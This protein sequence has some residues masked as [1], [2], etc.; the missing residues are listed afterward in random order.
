MLRESPKTKEKPVVIMSA[1]DDV[2]E[3]AEAIGADGILPK[4]FT[5]AALLDTIHRTL[6]GAETNAQAGAKTAEDCVD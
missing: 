5:P 6:D 1:L 4:P 3:R 2:E